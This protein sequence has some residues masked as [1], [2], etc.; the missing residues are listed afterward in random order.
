MWRL[1][2]E[3]GRSQSVL[4]LFSPEKEGSTQDGRIYVYG[5]NCAGRC[6]HP[7][8]ASCLEEWLSLVHSAE[9]GDNGL[10]NERY[11]E[12]RLGNASSRDISKTYFLSRTDHSN[13]SHVPPPGVLPNQLPRSSSTPEWPLKHTSQRRGCYISR[14]APHYPQRILLAQNRPSLTSKAQLARSERKSSSQPTDTRYFKILGYSSRDPQVRADGLS[15]VGG[16]M[17]Y[18]SYTALFT[19]HLVIGIGE[20]GNVS[21]TEDRPWIHE[22]P[23]IYETSG[24]LGKGYAEQTRGATAY[25]VAPTGDLTIA[26]S[27]GALRRPNLPTMKRG[28]EGTGGM[29]Q[30]L[31]RDLGVSRRWARPVLHRGP[32]RRCEVP[33][34]AKERMDG[35]RG[36][37]LGATRSDLAWNATSLPCGVESRGSLAAYEGTTVAAL[38]SPSPGWRTELEIHAP[39]GWEESDDGSLRRRT[40]RSEVQPCCSSSR[41]CSLLGVPIADT[42]DDL[43]SRDVYETSDIESLTRELSD[44]DILD[45]LTLRDLDMTLDTRDFDESEIVEELYRRRRGCMKRHTRPDGTKFYLNDGCK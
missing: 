4:F 33:G 12:L 2:L 9:V 19:G 29:D 25:S 34:V 8:V 38:P 20:P 43:T 17:V 6:M 15:F 11:P 1:P 32:L 41:R 14:T 40:Y 30:G 28:D 36:R 42:H 21:S 37:M 7:R 3:R 27:T 31:R 5:T 26:G 44:S 23:E 24:T 22:E 45:M 13:I 10:R 16:V 18:P 35:E 39:T